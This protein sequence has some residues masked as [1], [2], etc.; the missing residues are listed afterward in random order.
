M[1]HENRI[2]NEGTFPPYRGTD[3]VYLHMI[4]EMERSGPLAEQARYCY[5]Y[6]FKHEVWSVYEWPAYPTWVDILLWNEEMRN[7]ETP[8]SIRQISDDLFH[9]FISRNSLMNW[10]T[11]KF[12]ALG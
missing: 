3:L 10:C 1:A 9:V 2:S 5:L 11:V 12:Y 4:N 6:L 8:F 7:L